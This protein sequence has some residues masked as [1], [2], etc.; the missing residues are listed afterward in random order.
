MH[1]CFIR[2]GSLEFNITILTNEQT[3]NTIILIFDLIL[4]VCLNNYKLPKDIVGTRFGKL[5]VVSLDSYKQK[6]K[7]QRISFW[8]CKCDC[9]GEKVV[10]LQNLRRGHTK[11]CGCYKPYKK[12]LGYASETSL[13]NSYIRQATKRNLTFEL[14]RSEAHKLFTSNCYYCNIEPK[15]IHN[16]RSRN[17]GVFIY[18]GIDRIDN[19]KGYVIDNVVSCCGMCNISKH[20]RTYEFYLNWIKQSYEHLKSQGKIE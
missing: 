15:Q 12:P 1:H 8:Y 9:G 13:I 20:N 19:N 16:P 2:G 7:K 11:S 10:C 3:F 6:G 18:N 14:T 17:N 5:V 4:E